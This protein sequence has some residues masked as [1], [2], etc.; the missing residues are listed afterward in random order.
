MISEQFQRALAQVPF[1]FERDFY[2]SQIGRDLD[3]T[4]AIRHYIEDGEREGLKPAYGFDPPYVAAQLRARGHEPGS[5]VLLEYLARSDLDL[6]PHPLFDSRYYRSSV[7][8]EV[9]ETSDLV[10]FAQR[11]AL[12]ETR[13]SPHPLFDADFYCDRYGDITCL[14]IDAFQHY[15]TEGER[16]GFQPHPLFDLKYWRAALTELGVEIQCAAALS[17]YVSRRE[18]W[19]ASPYPLF[20]PAYFAGQLRGR[21][22]VPDARRP[23]LADLMIR[24]P[25]M[26]PHYLFDPDHYLRQVEIAGDPIVG[27]PLRHYAANPRPSRFNPHPLFDEE[28]YS[29]QVPE[30]ASDPAAHY[31]A[32]GW[33][34]GRDPSPLFSVKHYKAVSAEA[35][36][37]TGDP[38]AHYLERGG[39]EGIDPHPLFDSQRYRA[40]VPQAVAAPLVH[41][42]RDWLERG[43]PCPPWGTNFERRRAEAPVARPY[44]VVVVSHELTLT[45]A[46]LILLRI[47][48]Q[49]SRRFGLRVLTLA[50]NGGPL[51]EAFAEWSDVVDLTEPLALGVDEDAM[52]QWLGNSLGRENRPRLAIVNTACAPRLGAALDSAAI[53]TITLVHE[54]ASAF[55]REDFR[56]IFEASRFVVFPARYVLEEAHRTHP[57][58]EEKSV[59]I[60][61][62]LLDPEFGEGDA[63][64]ARQKLLD[65]IG[66]PDDAF[67]VLGCGTLD[68]RKGVDV[69]ARAAAAAN[70]LSP[71]ASPGRPLY[72]VWI[73]GGPTHPHSP[74]WYAQ[75]DIA[76]A[77]LSDRVIFLGPRPE[78]Q[79]YFLGC[80]AFALTSRMDPFPC[81]VHEAMACGKPVIA[82][83][84]SGGAPEA[85]DEDSGVVVPYGDADALAR[86]LR[87]LAD[88]PARA[89]ALGDRARRRV[90]ET[91]RFPEYVEKILETASERADVAF[92][93]RAVAWDRGR[94]IFTLA[95][96]RPNS[97]S[98]FVMRLSRA[99]S[100]RG[101]RSEVVFTSSDA[102][103]SEFTPPPGVQCRW[104]D[105]RSRDRPT[106]L[107]I[108]GLLVDGL[109]A[110]APAVF[111]HGTDLA[112]SAIAPVTPS[113]VGSLGLVF[114]DRPES[115]E[116]AVRLGRYWQKFVVTPRAD[117]ALR[118]AIPELAR[119]AVFIGAGAPSSPPPS[120]PV[121]EGPPRFACAL[122]A[123]SADGWTD[124]ARQFADAS[125][126]E[127]PAYVLLIPHPPRQSRMLQAALSVWIGR[128]L[129]Q[130]VSAA[131]FDD[132]LA[133]LAGCE[134]LIVSSDAPMPVEISE[135]MRMGLATLFVPQGAGVRSPR[136][137]KDGW[138]GFRLDAAN[139]ERARAVLGELARA[140][141][142]LAAM[143]H[144]AR[145][146]VAEAFSDWDGVVDRYAE[147]LEEML[148]ALRA[149]R[150]RRLDPPLPH[151]RFGGLSFPPSLR[152]N[153][154][155]DFAPLE[156]QGSD[157]APVWTHFGWK[158]AIGVAGSNAVETPVAEPG[159]QGFEIP[160]SASEGRLMVRL[161]VNA[162]EAGEISI[163]S[164]T[165]ME[166]D[167]DPVTE[168]K[169]PLRAGRNEIKAHIRRPGRVEAIRMNYDGPKDLLHLRSAQVFVRANGGEEPTPAL[170]PGI[171]ADCAVRGEG[172]QYL[173][174]SW[175][176]AE[177]T[178]RWSRAS[179]G[180]MS[181]LAEF[182]DRAELRLW[183]LCRVT[184]TQ[185][186]GAIPV[187]VRMRDG[188]QIALWMFPD[189]NWRLQS[190][191]LAP[192]LRGH[193]R[194][195]RLQLA[196]DSTP[197]PHELGLAPD[198]RELG[199][200][201]RAFGLFPLETP[202][203]QVASTFAGL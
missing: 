166:D 131:N 201:V 171:V 89:A 95:D 102:R 57:L 183:T 8:G 180:E 15:L 42:V 121:G 26:A 139:P 51:R 98:T 130:L 105:W 46:P 106:F 135:T 197:S 12:G 90:H 59:V 113:R 9:D 1:M 191:R 67:V 179:G 148:E 5:S 176:P 127:A 77:G 28:F 186:L 10:D 155:A 101:F 72:F 174:G 45:G 143:Q 184:G 17:D 93:S 91:Y 165:D 43:V 13:I 55:P 109:R 167:F 128:G 38:I 63:G 110:A 68:L 144:A 6:D 140:P 163:Q 132:F 124:F 34:E 88:D 200:A 71:G 24:K 169:A 25:A 147:T 76:R 92:E 182:P 129:V 81:V 99:L 74:A 162:T 64:E 123:R 50:A 54:L 58:P 122:S 146:S 66:A 35:R 136:E 30:A 118:K 47:V 175:Y 117:T 37:W 177:E 168:F 164:R 49:L 53:P 125:G 4:E 23:P 115:L 78:P 32:T 70:R 203:L 154:D 160:V 73:G 138:N 188:A 80:D 158:E 79:S 83:A 100:A 181:F 173:A 116:Q 52:V 133:A 193:A 14:G 2:V 86:A 198:G 196:R 69:F 103:T 21:G 104:L 145:M 126:S 19:M 44:D 65:E 151:P 202:E 7:R 29:V 152:L 114:D 39:A 84:N 82:F 36:R 157:T 153:P 60:P 11:R 150:Y 108:T 61:Q 120:L 97:R 195:L 156:G 149:G 40:Q 194:P 96:A 33:R 112:G 27:H 137:L 189:E 20:D 141:E 187:R 192:P 134:A 161:E 178:L 111:V 56:L 3:Q 22:L 87:E 159:G 48:V 142:R 85:L 190:V 94:V 172:D 16:A 41:Y 62:G 119:R 18:T 31:L 107:E 75:Q 199:V 170:P 185:A